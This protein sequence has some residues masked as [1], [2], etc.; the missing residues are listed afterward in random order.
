MDFGNLNNMTIKKFPKEISFNDF[1]RMGLLE[2]FAIPDMPERS[3]FQTITER[4]YRLNQLLLPYSKKD[5]RLE[6]VFTGCGR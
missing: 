1:S 2:S 4:N 3:P 6:A 5:L